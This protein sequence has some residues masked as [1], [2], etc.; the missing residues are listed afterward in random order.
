[1]RIIV[2][3]AKN[4]K[5]IVDGQVV[6]AIDKGLMLLVGMTHTDTSFDAEYCAK[7]IA[8]L[9]IFE[10]DAGKLNLSVK[11]IGGAIL[12]ISQFT[13]YGNVEKGNRPSFTDAAR[14]ELAEPLYHEFNEILK[15]EHCLH[16]ET[17]VFGAM[18][19]ID[20]VNEGPVTLVV[21]RK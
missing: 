9:R 13:L 5:V 7:K 11:D 12:S 4:A 6:G 21:E 2:Q 10:D 20:F 14:P 8:N 18:M 17:G 3:R 15:T 19:D 1:M 16:V